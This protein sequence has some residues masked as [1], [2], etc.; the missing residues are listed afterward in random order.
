[1]GRGSETREVR[2]EP[3]LSQRN[4]RI[5][6]GSGGV[7]AGMPDPGGRARLRTDSVYLDFPGHEPC[8]RR[9]SEFLAESRQ[10][11][12]ASYFSTEPDAAVHVRVQHDPHAGTKAATIAA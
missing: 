5:N 8:A 9:G 3:G 7:Q 12:L 4:L 11:L 2:G 10:S 1:M 6:P